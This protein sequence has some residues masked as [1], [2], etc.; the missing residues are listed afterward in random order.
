MNSFNTINTKIYF[1]FKRLLDI[2]GSLLGLILGFPF[3]LIISILI[4]LDS[5]GPVFFKQKRVG[6]GYKEFQM[7]KF[8]TMVVDAEKILQSNPKLMEIYKKSSYKI[9][10]DPRVTKVGKI[11][12]KLS[13][14]ELPQLIN[15]FRGEMSI[16][17]PRAYKKDEIENQLGIHPKLGKYAK[18]VTSIKPGLTGLW[19]TGGRSEIGFEQ[20]IV[21]DYDYASRMSILF[22]IA[23]ILK[24]FPAVLKSKGAW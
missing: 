20:R 15:I 22:D 14:D 12:R 21:L 6:A 17:G 5:K 7:W 1:L 23:I 8:R 10:D 13:I 4:K 24:T 11:L 19:Q 3:F 16:V 9:K 18:V 2:A